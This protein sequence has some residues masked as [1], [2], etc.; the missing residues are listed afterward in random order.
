MKQPKYNY[1]FMQNETKAI[2][3]IIVTLNIVF[4]NQFG[5]S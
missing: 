1:F 2:N 5:Y 3:N 4:S